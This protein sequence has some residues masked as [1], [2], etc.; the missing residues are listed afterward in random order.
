MK[1]RFI[2]QDPEY[3]ETSKAE[4][5]EDDR[6]WD[7]WM[8]SPTQGTWVWASSGRWWSTGKPG[9]ATVYEVAKSWTRLSNWTTTNRCRAW[10]LPFL[11]SQL[12]FNGDFCL[13]TYS[14]QR[15]EY[16]HPHNR[17]EQKRICLAQETKSWWEY[18][19][20]LLVQQRAELL[21]PNH[22]QE[23]SLLR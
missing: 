23:R 2:R 22:S 6:G 8:A 3:W 12:Y 9:H 20:F 18:K 4:G 16:K 15:K 21:Q 10:A 7:G 13:L 17:G 11:P 19:V 5:E 1:S 14:T